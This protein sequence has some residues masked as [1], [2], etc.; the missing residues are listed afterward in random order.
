M[1]VNFTIITQQKRQVIFFIWFILFIFSVLSKGYGQV[2]HDTLIA[3]R[4]YRIADSLS[5]Q[6]YYEQSLVHFNKAIPIYATAKAWERVTR[7]YN[8]ISDSQLENGNRQ[9][10][11]YSAQKALE[12]CQKKLSKNHREA[13][14]AYENM[15]I[16]NSQKPNKF[17]V[18]LQYLERALKIREFTEDTIGISDSYHA[19][20]NLYF[21]QREYDIALEYYQKSLDIRKRKLG[22]DHKRT[23]ASY[24][25][26]GL[27]YYRKQDYDKSLKFL[28]KSISVRSSLT[29]RIKAN[30]AQAKIYRRRG[31]S[32]KVISFLEKNFKV[33]QSLRTPKNYLLFKNLNL[34]GICYKDKGEYDEALKYYSKAININNKIIKEEGR[35]YGS[36]VYNNIGVVYK[37]KGE[38]DKALFY[39]R[40]A[41]KENTKIRRYE[42]PSSVALYHNNLANTF[43]LR[44]EY[45]IA[46]KYYFKALRI[47][48]KTLAPNHSDLADSYNDI[49]ELYIATQQYDSATFYYNKALKIRKHVY[50]ENNM[51]V[52]DSYTSIAKLFFDQQ[53]YSQSLIYHQ[54]AR[55]IRLELLGT[56]HPKVALSYR[57]IAKVYTIQQDYN[58]A[59]GYYQKALFANQVK[60]IRNNAAK[61]FDPNQYMD[62]RVLLQT[63]ADQA[64]A[65][66][67]RYVQSCAK[68]DLDLTVISYQ[69]ADL[70][71]QTIRETYTNYQDKVAFAQQVKEVYQ[72]AI[73]TQ[74]QLFEI[75]QDEQH[76]F[77]AFAYAE[78]S[79][80][81]TLKEIL[82]ASN[83]KQFVGLPKTITILEKELKTNT[84]FYLSR[85]SQERAK[86]KSDTTKIVGYENT[87]FRIKRRQDSLQK[88]LRSNYPEYYKLRYDNTIISVK[89]IQEKI[90]EDTTVLEFFTS[91]SITY[92]FVITKHKFS[93]K[94]LPVTSLT[95]KV[96]RF[97]EVLVTQ[98]FQEYKKLGHTLYNELM[99]PVSD[100][101]EGRNLIIIPD[102][103]L[104]HCNFDL[105]LMQQDD[106]NNPAEV[107]YVLKKYAISYSNAATVLFA[108]KVEQSTALK[109]EECLAFSY[110]DTTQL[111]ENES[112]TLAALRNSTIDLPGTRREI[113][114]IS[115]IIDGQYYYG[116]QAGE[117]NFKKLS[118]QYNILHLALHGDIDSEHP[119]NS[120]LY[121]SKNKDTVQDNILYSHELFSMSIPADLTVLSAC[122]TGSGKIANGEGIMSLGSAFQYAGTKSVLLT[123]WAVSDRTTPEIMQYFYE[124]LKK[125]M[126][127]SQALQQ[128]KLSY[129]ETADI[130]R[131][132]PFYW[133][134]FYLIG[135][136]SPIPFEKNI[137]TWIFGVLILGILFLLLVWYQKRKKQQYSS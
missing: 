89:D 57:H 94:E 39:F 37:Y 45:N 76:L 28:S 98:D 66:T 58:Q 35:N 82:N 119:E 136:V 112:V 78:K 53:E 64:Q 115:N 5:S 130:N 48:E 113:K 106:S 19:L 131:I 42:H 21:F 122:N 74:L 99:L 81:N 47:R 38:Y 95:N 123:N 93:I 101:F 15:G 12:I 29:N 60:N 7:C 90:D 8:K 116:T 135:D 114:A 51:Y 118:D 52:A 36:S 69:K 70:L 10:S 41:L 86:E 110:S 87:L 72:G 13:A 111:Y 88:V 22:I 46:L 92:A 49:G 85:I 80:A 59:L 83:A 137:S 84:S 97:K 121:F 129:L 54:K 31:D 127:K 108:D 125:G 77:Q 63:L 27:A 25:G 128:A 91:E 117:D 40:K 16:I 23:A 56:H 50:E 14:F 32:D 105:L 109:R 68:D 18:S 1:Y 30:E 26:I 55:A 61:S 6:G 11:L 43:R 65:Y 132:A 34:T 3:Y 102:G 133:G 79:K 62:H 33:L 124:N 67:N 9:E 4:N 71:I 107:S 96:E 120:R 73:Q 17:K 24:L 100:T 20:G 75:D 2:T 104:W 126:R 44:K 134:G 103:A